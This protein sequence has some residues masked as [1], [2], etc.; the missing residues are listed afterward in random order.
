MNIA[1][2]QS[3]NAFLAYEA[4]GKIMAGLADGSVGQIVS[5]S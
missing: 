5:K 4:A 1:D 3:P 2:E